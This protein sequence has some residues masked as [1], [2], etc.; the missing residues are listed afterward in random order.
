[1]KEFLKNH[2]LVILITL[3]AVIVAVV[4]N[5]FVLNRAKAA[6]IIIDY[7]VPAKMDT[8]YL[9]SR[10]KSIK[11]K[12]DTFKYKGNTYETRTGKKKI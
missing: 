7:D 3:I 10:A 11:A 9:I 4:F 5:P 6:Q 2:G 1:M 8:G 12:K